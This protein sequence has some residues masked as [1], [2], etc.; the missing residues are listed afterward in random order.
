MPSQPNILWYCTDQQ[1]FDTISALG[2]QHI[3]HP[4]S[5][6]ICVGIRHILPMLIASR[7]SVRLVVRVF[8]RACILAQS[9]STGMVI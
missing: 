5:R 4:K 2:N 1:R 8:Y 7:R 9:V 6:S 3:K